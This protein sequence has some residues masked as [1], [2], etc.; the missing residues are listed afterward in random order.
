M[1]LTQRGP[2]TTEDIPK[3]AS[4]RERGRERERELGGVKRK[5]QSPPALYLHN[6]IH[7][8]SNATQKAVSSW[9]HLHFMHH[10]R[11]GRVHSAIYTIAVVRGSK[12]KIKA[13][14]KQVLL[15]KHFHYHMNSM[16]ILQNHH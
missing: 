10:T 12:E 5:A 11:P 6:D 8:H 15:N 16:K 13:S 2:S 7:T 1:M 9:Q 3:G 4:K 14:E